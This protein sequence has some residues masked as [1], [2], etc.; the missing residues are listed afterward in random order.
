MI[1]NKSVLNNTVFPIDL[2]PIKPVLSAQAIMT[3][4]MLVVLAGAVMTG[5]IHATLVLLPVIWALN[6]I[7][8]AGLN[9]LLS[10]INV[11]FRD[12]E[13]FVS[14]ILMV[15][16]VA[17][18]IAYTPAMV[19]SSLK[20]LLDL[21]PFAYFV[22]AY[23]VSSS[24]VLWHVA[25][26]RASRSACHHAPRRLLVWELVLRSHK[27]RGYRLCLILLVSLR[28][29]GKCT[30][31]S[32]PAVPICLMPSDSTD[33]LTDKANVIVSSGPSA[34]SISVLSPAPAWASSVVMEPESQRCLNS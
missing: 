5:N 18:P 16:L 12:L 2:A 14:A 17:S 33:S 28:A 7:W 9:W 6:I 30:R 22:V 8:L 27:A 20:L 10:V 13:N 15:M 34:T 31:F 3:A 32:L 29:L 21:N 26:H 1:A 23:Q 19:P 11:I 25:E 4:G 24:H